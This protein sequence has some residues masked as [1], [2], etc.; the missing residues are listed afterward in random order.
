MIDPVLVT[1]FIGHDNLYEKLN[2][3]ILDDWKINK[4]L[5]ILKQ[6]NVY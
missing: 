3:E 1:K 4:K 2:V 5:L 6:K